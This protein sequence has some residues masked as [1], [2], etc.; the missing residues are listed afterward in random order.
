MAEAEAEAT[1]EYPSTREYPVQ[2]DPT[3]ANAGLTE[4]NDEPF[5]NGHAEETAA[6]TGVPQSE[7]GGG[8]AVAEANWDHS[9]ADMS[10]SQEWVNVTPRDATETDTG[11]SATFAAPAQTQSWADEQPDT[12]PPA[13]EVSS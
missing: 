13:A 3:M 5:T 2:S 4:I 11:V 10:T 1:P 8:N 12:P 9:A 7:I 6:S